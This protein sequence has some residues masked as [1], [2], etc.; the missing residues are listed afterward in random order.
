VPVDVG[1]SW[2]N[3]SMTGGSPS[4]GGGAG[5]WVAVALLIL[6]VAGGGFFVWKNSQKGTP[7]V[8]GSTPGATSTPDTDYSDLTPDAFFKRAKEAFAKKKYEQAAREAD[9]CLMMFKATKGT[10]KAKI[11]EAEAFVRKTHQAY[12]KQVLTD[13]N[14]L[15]K[16]RNYNKALNTAEQAAEILAKGNAPKAEIAKAYAMVARCYKKVNSLADAEKYFKMAMSY[17]PSGSYGSELNAVR[18]DMAPDPVPEEVEAPTIEQPSLGEGGPGYQTASR[19]YGSGG[20]GSRPAPAAAAPAAE[21]PRRQNPA[22]VYVPKAK[23]APRPKGGPGFYNT[24]NRFG[25][26]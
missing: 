26:Y 23:P 24:P 16:E 7:V 15:F 3:T 14:K 21:A 5:A 6:A 4:R 18:D 8:A 25:R 2:A 1:T 19:K 22:A 11:K 12:G 17:N 10:P 9:D 13:A 20:G